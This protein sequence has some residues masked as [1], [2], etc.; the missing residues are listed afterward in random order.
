MKIGL[1]VILSLG[2]FGIPAATEAQPVDGC[3][4]SGS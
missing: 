1:A 4:V 2:L 3:R